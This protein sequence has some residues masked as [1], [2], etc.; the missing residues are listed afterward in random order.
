MKLL[1]LLLSLV[2]AADKTVYLNSTS[3]DTS[4]AVLPDS[5]SIVKTVSQRVANTYRDTTKLVK[6][7]TIRTAHYDTLRTKKGK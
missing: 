3:R 4:K 5:V 7:D 2:F 6:S 1:L